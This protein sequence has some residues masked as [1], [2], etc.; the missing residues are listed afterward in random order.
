MNMLVSF[1]ESFSGLPCSVK[2]AFIIL[3]LASIFVV[4]LANKKR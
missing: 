4:L 2:A 3:S 1:L